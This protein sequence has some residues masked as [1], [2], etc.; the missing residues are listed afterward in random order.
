[1]YLESK[2]KK[3]QA[4]R[5][6]R[7]LFWLLVLAAGA[8][9]VVYWQEPLLVFYQEVQLA[10]N[11]PDVEQIL[12]EQRR[13]EFGVYCLSPEPVEGL[14]PDCYLFDKDGIVFAKA[15]TV[16]G[17]VILRVEEV[18]D[19]QAKIGQRFLPISQW[20]NL[21]KILDYISRGSWSSSVF[22]L[23]RDQEEIILEGPP[24]LLFSLRFDP[25]K[26][27]AALTELKKKVKVENLAYLDLRVEDK[28]FY[29]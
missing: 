29:K 1:M 28:I 14:G 26:H 2:A 16:V 12:K 10:L 18:S 24:K 11:P 8:A 23:K 27:L 15:K 22:R 7:R 20:S 4:R 21:L 5:R 17:E 25:E 13:Q 19:Y 3:H 9:A 6:F